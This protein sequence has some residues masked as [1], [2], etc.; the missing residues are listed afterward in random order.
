MSEFKRASSRGELFCKLESIDT[1]FDFTEGQCVRF[2]GVSRSHF[3]KDSFRDGVEAVVIDLP[4][5]TVMNGFRNE[6]PICDQPDDCGI[7]FSGLHH[8]FLVKFTVS[9]SA[10]QAELGYLYSCFATDEPFPIAIA[11]DSIT[12][13]EGF[14]LPNFPSYVPNALLYDAYNW[15]CSTF[16]VGQGMASFV[17]NDIGG[18]LIDAGAGTP[19]KRKDYTSGSLTSNDLMARVNGRTVTFVLSHGDEDHWRIL[20]WDA[21]LCGQI[22]SF[23]IPNTR[24]SIAFFDKTIKPRVRQLSGHSFLSLSATKKLSLFRTSPKTPTSNNDG[25]VALF[26]DGPNAVLMPGDCVYKELALDKDAAVQALVAR[27]YCAVVVP[28]HGDFA[29]SLN[30]PIAQSAGISKAFFSAGNH[31][32]YKHPT[33]GSE[34][35]HASAGYSGIVNKTPTGI[36][37]HQLK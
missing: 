5:H 32:K 3:N 22:V 9:G 6:I 11:L 23:V 17:Y 1:D 14:E 13:L 28:H 4:I 34:T 33:P 18:F 15:T 16:E 30:V 12:R 36:V 21:Q 29:S 37:E 20:R 7:C 2:I 10:A 27:N 8:W 26:E 19:I 31:V 25:I 35:S 24:P